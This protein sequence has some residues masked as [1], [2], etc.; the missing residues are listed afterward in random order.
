MVLIPVSC[1]MSRTSFTLILHIKW[2]GTFEKWYKALQP[3][4]LWDHVIQES[5]VS[6]KRKCTPCVTVTAP[7][8]VH[9]QGPRHMHSFH[10]CL[11]ACSVSKSR[12]PLCD[13]TD[14]SPLGSY[15][16]GMPQARILEWVVISFP[17]GS[18]WPRDGTCISC[19]GRWI[20]NHLG[21]PKRCLACSRYINESVGPGQ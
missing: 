20:L 18:F 1:T 8:C 13:P 10:R 15:V 5:G 6:H 4:W 21:R 11:H 16:H 19:I 7:P 2:D 17:R 12:P 14:Y 3:C 9:L